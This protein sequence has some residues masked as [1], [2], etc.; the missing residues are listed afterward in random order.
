MDAWR[1]MHKLNNPD[2]VAGWLFIAVTNRCK[3]HLRKMLSRGK[4]EAAFVETPPCNPGHAMD[5]ADLEAAL[6]RS[7][8]L[9]PEEL[10]TVIMMK[11][12]AKMSY[13]EISAM[14]GLSPTTIDGRLRTGKRMLKE[15][16]VSL[17]FG[18]D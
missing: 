15:K 11:Y 13:R 14:T 18:M 12:F 10:R 1:N 2:T 4:C 7:I 8:F 9:L 17:G 6:S 5:A 3:D 16:L